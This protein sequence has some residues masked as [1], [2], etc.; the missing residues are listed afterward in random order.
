[1]SVKIVY[2]EKL[3]TANVTREMTV[4][5]LRRGAS[6]SLNLDE[7]KFEFKYGD[8]ILIDQKPLSKY[9]TTNLTMEYN[10]RSF[11]LMI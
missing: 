8:I 7:D 5:N 6:Q 4:Q 11:A 2:R 3:Y 1:M 9:L 10:V